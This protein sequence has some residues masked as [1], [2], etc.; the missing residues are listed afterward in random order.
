MGNSETANQVEDH[1]DGRSVLDDHKGLVALAGFVGVIVVATIVIDL[2]W[3]SMGAAL[4]LAWGLFMIVTVVLFALL[5]YYA[6]GY[7]GYRER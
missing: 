2:F 7:L 5:P 3:S 1:V 4:V 6:I